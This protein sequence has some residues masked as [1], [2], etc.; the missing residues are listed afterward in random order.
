MNY[1]VT[2]IQNIGIQILPRRRLVTVWPMHDKQMMLIGVRICESQFAVHALGV[3]YE[4]S[5]MILQRLGALKLP[6]AQVAECLWMFCCAVHSKFSLIT[7]S[8][9]TFVARGMVARRHVVRR[10]LP[11]I[12]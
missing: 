12:E 2:I 3:C 11:G 5:D 4:V 8:D 10:K 1:S 7:E 6:L 9:L